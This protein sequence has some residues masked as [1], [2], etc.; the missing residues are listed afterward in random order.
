MDNR[1][2]IIEKLKDY[3]ALL[4]QNDFPMTIDKMYLFGSFAK[5]N[6]HKESDIDVAFIV[7]EW[8][9]DYFYV[10]PLLWKIRREIDMRIEPHVIVPDEDYAGLY[11]EIKKT[12]VEIY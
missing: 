11:D 2:N 4:K 3:K 7:P 12:G 1:E 8:E 5:G 6:T 9:G 10:M